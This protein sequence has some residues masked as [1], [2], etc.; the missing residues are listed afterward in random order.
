MKTV[1]SEG[2]GTEELA[3]AIADYEA[4]LKKENLVFKKNVE[5]WQERLVEMLRDAML[6]KARARIGRR[7]PGALRG[8]DRRAQARSVFAGGGDCARQQNAM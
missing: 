3:E 8:R 6:E 5:N 1:A 4:Y 2:V 7:Q